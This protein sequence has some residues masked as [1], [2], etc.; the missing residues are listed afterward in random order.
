[1]GGDEGFNFKNNFGALGST[2]NYQAFAAQ[3]EVNA[4]RARITALETDNAELWETIEK[5][6]NY[7]GVELKEEA[8][9]V[10]TKYV[11]KT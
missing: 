8:V 9:K 6:E 1:M 3:H 2:Y 10:E 5:L 4:L 7:L 11:K